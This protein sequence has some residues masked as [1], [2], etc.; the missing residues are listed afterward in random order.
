MM[1]PAFATFSIAKW[2]RPKSMRLPARF[3]CGGSTLVVKTLKLGY[4]ACIASPI[5]SK[6]RIGSAPASV[7]WKA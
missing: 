6:T 1:P 5:W 3:G 4:P 2:M 7:R